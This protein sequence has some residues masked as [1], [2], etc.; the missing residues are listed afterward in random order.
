MSLDAARAKRE[1]ADAARLPRR[2]EAELP[3]WVTSV[4]G[5]RA[6]EL[7][8][9]QGRVALTNAL[10]ARNVR[11]GSGG[12]FAALVWDLDRGQ[13]V[14]AGV[15]L[16]LAS[17]LSSL[18]AET[19]ALSLAQTR[20]GAW[21]LSGAR[22]QLV[23]NWRPCIMCFGAVIWS[24]VRDLAIA[25]S[26]PQMERITGFDEGPVPARWREE[27]ERRGIRV[28]DGL[29]REAALAVFRDYAARGQ[30]AYNPS[31]RD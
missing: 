13:L 8:D 9:V 6:G 16:V 29:A 5:E 19:V 3:A 21:D 14:S 26:G 15:N 18:H 1:E 7:A 17:H 12:P 23:V 10:A 22:R 20:L 27:L 4:V 2:I 24:G 11:E 28:T 31:G 30:R 25:G